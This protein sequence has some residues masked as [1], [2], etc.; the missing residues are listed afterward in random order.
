MNEA[1]SNLCQDK[2]GKS[3]RLCITC[4]AKLINKLDEGSI[5]VSEDTNTYFLYKHMKISSEVLKNENVPYSPGYANCS[6]NFI[7][8]QC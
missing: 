5:S 4:L 7:N 2:K 1:C 8:P 6:L 3:F